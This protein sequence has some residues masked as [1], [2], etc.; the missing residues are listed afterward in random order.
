MKISI[1]LHYIRKT[2]SFSIYILLS[3]ITFQLSFY[4][5]CTRN[6]KTIN[7]FVYELWHST[8]IKT[9]RVKIRFTL[10]KS[11]LFHELEDMKIWSCK[12]CH[13]L[14]KYFSHC[15]QSAPLQM[16]N[17]VL[18]MSPALNIPGFWICQ[19]FGYTRFPK[20]PGLQGYPGF[21]IYMNNSW[22]CL[23]M[24]GYVWICWNMGE[25]A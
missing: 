24:C 17:K 6:P 8:R 13:N 23:I 4:F 20:R 22:I 12:N 11:Y 1:T 3:T 10:N 5:I 14:R 2:T 16:F 19:R 18:S 25:Y 21:R 15:F 9:S 7:F